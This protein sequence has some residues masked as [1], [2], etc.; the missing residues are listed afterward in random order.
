MNVNGVE[1]MV[2]FVKQLH[3]AYPDFH[4]TIGESAFVNDLSFNQWT[5]TGTATRE[6]GTTTPI[7]VNGLTMVRYADG[8]IAE[9]WVYFDSAQITNQMG[10]SAMPHAE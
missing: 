2:A 9:E 1:E 3:A 5:V 6:D 8:K 4:I 10:G 7:E